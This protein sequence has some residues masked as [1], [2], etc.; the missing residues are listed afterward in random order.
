[1]K[2]DN[3]YYVSLLDSLA[4]ILKLEDFQAEVFNP[5]ENHS[6]DQLRD[7]CDGSVFKSH[8]IFSLDPH[9]LQVVAYYD[10]LEVVNPIGS[11]IKKHK[12]GCMFYFLANVRPQYRSSLKSIQL[13]AVG[14]QEDIVK[15]GIDEF[16]APFVED[17]K[18]LYCNGL[19][20]SVGGVD[21]VLHG[22]LLAFLAD[23]L[24]AHLVGGFKQSMSFALR[25][26]RG[27]M[28]TRELS[29]KCFLESD[30]IM[31]TAESPF[32][33]CALLT[34]PLSVHHS[35][36]YGINRL[37]ILEEVPGFS[38]TSGLPHDIMHDLF[39]GVV[40]LQMKLLLCH[41]VSQKYFTI[42]ELNERIT[43]FDFLDNKP[44]EI[45][46]NICR[47]G[48]SKI[49]QSASQMMA[50][51]R[52][53]ALIIGD[54][55]PEGEPHWCIFLTLFRICSI[56]VAPVCT[57]DLMAYL[58]ICVEDY[59]CMFRE[60]YPCETIIPKQHYMIHYAT[61]MEKFGPLIHSWTMRQESK[62]RF[63]KRVSQSSNYKNVPKTVA[64]RHQFWIC[65]HMQSDCPMLTP[66][67]EVGPKQLCN[68]LSCEDDY[69][70][71]ELKRSIPSLGADSVV[72]HPKWVDLQS[73][74]FCK[75]LYILIKYD[76]MHPVFGK[77]IDLV[78]IETTLIICVVE[79]YG[80]VFSP[81][82]NAFIIKSRGVVSAINVDTG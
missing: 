28:I 22:G 27:C 10:E 16:L 77:I 1:M 46:S 47:R 5:H 81:H 58:R 32:E 8:P 24:A 65:Y 26:C 55:V 57:H 38:V 40:P 44:S 48:D 2:S 33:Q 70:Q 42:E 71:H 17:V 13:L 15:Y 78:T 73:S 29:Q 74:H 53:F 30:C 9:A 37:S 52:E 64:Q 14:K 21:R 54:K 4:N 20:V 7:Y 56:A 34:G 79:Y 3:F 41:C 59:L 18:T 19:T 23:N 66:Q 6:D 45:D 82:Y 63:V 50:L 80:D 61:Q 49:K 36:S 62:L 35:T 76:S 12:L 51:C 31:R 11:Y 39:E 67:F 72:Y 68:T 43:A 75:G 69:I 60:L 25:I